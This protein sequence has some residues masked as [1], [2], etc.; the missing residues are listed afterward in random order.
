M[1]DVVGAVDV[2]NDLDRLHAIPGCPDYFITKRGGVWSEK[3]G[4]PRPMKLL[5][6][7]DGYLWLSLRLNGNNKTCLL[8]RLLGL[9]FIENPEALPEINHK[10]LN[11]LN[12]D[13]TNLEWVSHEENIVHARKEYGSAKSKMRKP[14]RQKL[15]DEMVREI[16][17]RHAEGESQGQL[18][19]EFDYPQGTISRIV[20]NDIWKWVK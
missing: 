2:V 15:N 8:H 3:Y 20:N 4:D 7:A 12:N 18:S 9:T 14:R 16:R 10:D 6:N 13:L 19:K 1:V 11:K 5:E 17:D